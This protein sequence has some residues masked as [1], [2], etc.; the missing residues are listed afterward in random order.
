[1]QIVVGSERFA[2]ISQAQQYLAAQPKPVMIP[3]EV[4][5]RARHANRR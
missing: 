4:I 5:E 3:R 1:M 2:A